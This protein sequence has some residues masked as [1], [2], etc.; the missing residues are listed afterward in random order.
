MAGEVKSPII[1]VDDWFDGRNVLLPLRSQGE[2]W[3]SFCLASSGHSR[4]EQKSRLS[5][6]A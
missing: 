4:M 1:V 6:G 5:L 3:R 2:L